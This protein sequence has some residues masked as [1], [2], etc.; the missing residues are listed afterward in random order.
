M[1]MYMYIY[2]YVYILCTHTYIHTHIH[3]FWS[4]KL[5]THSLKSEPCVRQTLKSAPCAYEDDI[6]VRHSRDMPSLPPSLSLVN[7]HTYSNTR[8][9]SLSHPPSH[10]RI[11]HKS[12]RT[13]GNSH[14]HT[15]S[16]S[17]TVLLFFL[18][19]SLS[20]AYTHTDMP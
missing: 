1:Y 12:E 13:H 16:L 11:C 19:L 8:T 6:I 20:L 7:Q 17:I 2:K 15:L 9:I 10:T 3:I 18:S 5:S 14:K 4:Q